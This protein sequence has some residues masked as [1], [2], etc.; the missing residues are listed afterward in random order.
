MPVVTPSSHLSLVSKYN[1]MLSDAQLRVMQA[2]YCWRDDIARRLD[3]SINYVLP[4]HTLISVVSALPSDSTALLEL[5]RPASPVLSQHAIE[6][7]TLINT[8]RQVRH[9]R[10]RNL[11]FVP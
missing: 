8:A 9:K 10:I 2:L 5:C 7:A 4:T 6:L 3:E 1:L 11:F